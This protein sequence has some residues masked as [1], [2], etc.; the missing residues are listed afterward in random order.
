MKLAKG[1][2]S[3]MDLLL[4][5]F[6]HMLVVTLLAPD[7]RLIEGLTLLTEMSRLWGYWGELREA[8]ALR[9]NPRGHLQCLIPT[10]WPIMAMSIAQRHLNHNSFTCPLINSL[11]LPVWHI[12]SLSMHYDGRGF[13][14]NISYYIVKITPKG[15]FLKKRI[16]GKKSCLEIIHYNWLSAIS[17]FSMQLNP[18]TTGN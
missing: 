13:S 17:T 5:L 12:Q 1:H 11:R 6:N 4:S 18:L 8:S 9:L 10:L 15:T 14:K 3:A 16:L 7:P 2:R